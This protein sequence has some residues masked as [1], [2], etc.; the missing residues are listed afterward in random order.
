MLP[1]HD[2]LRPRFLLRLG[3]FLYDHLG[4]RK[5]L[6]P[7]RTVDLTTDVTGQPL[8]ND[9]VVGY[10][11]SDCWVEDARLVALSA[12]DAAKRG[13]VIRT[14]T[15]CTAARREG[16]VWKIDIAR[17]GKTETITAK[18]LV[19]AAG[20]WVSNVLGGVIGK[21]DPDKIRMVKGSHIV[22]DRLYDH[23]RCYIFQN[24]DG[25]ICFAIP[26]NRTS[27]SSAPPT[28]TTRAIPASR[29]FPTRKRITSSMQ[30]ANT[31]ACR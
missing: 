6:P 1:H 7:T 27:P 17:D 14:R 4:G 5:I 9:F 21:N 2:G 18:A 11:Y 28:R 12:R 24:A 16:G 10:E 31:S 26:T 3:L 20:P 19:N 25:R 29:R 23:D 30:S 15:K 13:A 22:V 8:K